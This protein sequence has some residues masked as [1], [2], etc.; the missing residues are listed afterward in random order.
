MVVGV[1]EV[2][3]EDLHLAR[4]QALVAVA[5]RGPGLDARVGRRELGVLRHHPQL[6]LPGEG[7]LA[8]DVPAG[9]EG[10]LVLFDVLLRR[11]MRRV[12][13]AGAE[14]HEE[15]LVGGRD[16]LRVDPIDGMVDEVLVEVVAVLGAAGRID[17]VVVL[18]QVRLPLA[19]LP[20]EEPVEALEPLPQRPAVVRPRCAL[21][22]VWREV[23]LSQCHGVKAALDQHRRKH[24]GLPGDA[25]VVAGVAGGGLHYGRNADGVVVAAGE[26]GCARRRAQ[27]R[28]VEVDVADALVGQPVHVG[29]PDAPAQSAVAT[30]LGV[31]RVVEDDDQDVRRAFRRIRRDR[32]RPAAT[33]SDLRR[34][35]SALAQWAMPMAGPSR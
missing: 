3:G 11:V 15:R 18:P 1:S 8:H 29:R 20:G 4:E 23:P 21:V 33:I 25:R 13:R 27:G 5:E 17:L 26:K 12:H 34:S 22:L 28:G 9:V 2:C 30:E 10:S 6:F 31:T 16:F 7:L 32:P 14:V 35:T 19:R 24:R